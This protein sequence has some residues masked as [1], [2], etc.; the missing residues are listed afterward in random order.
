MFRYTAIRIQREKPSLHHLWPQEKNENKRLDHS[1]TR[2]DLIQYEKGKK[3]NIIAYDKDID[4]KKLWSLHMLQAWSS[5]DIKSR[6]TWQDIRYN[7]QLVTF[8]NKN[9]NYRRKKWRYHLLRINRNIFRIWLW[10][11]QFTMDP[12][13]IFDYLQNRP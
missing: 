1:Y 8:T 3:L 7:K 10:K 9:I 13:L 5:H 11:F 4:K 12:S 2:C 6:I